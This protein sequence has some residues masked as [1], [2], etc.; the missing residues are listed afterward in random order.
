[1]TSFSFTAT[2]TFTITHA[3]HI[4]SKI[5]TDLKRMQ[6]FYGYPSDLEITEYEAEAIELLR[7]GYLDTVTYGFKK[8]ENWIV[9]T[10]KYAAKDLVN[11]GGL[12]DDPGRVPV[13]ANIE[14]AH[15]HSYLTRNQAWWNLSETERERIQGTLPFKRT[16]APYPGTT[17]YFSQDK[18]YNSGGKGVDRF[19]LKNY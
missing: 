3:R 5:A 18:S 12:D 6:R 17:G 7:L 8:G 2:Q 10:L 4:A 13:G 9:P 19:T 1:M 15:F 11:A 14:G 16:G